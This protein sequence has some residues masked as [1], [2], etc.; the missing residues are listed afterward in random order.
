MTS[1]T[2]RVKI[3]K[4]L[5]VQ[6]LVNMNYRILTLLG[7]ATSIVSDYKALEAYHDKSK[8]CDWFMSAIQAVVYEN[9]PLP[10]LP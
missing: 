6:E 7:F 8:K 1:I 3:M 10:S 2:K 5:D 4:E 9:K